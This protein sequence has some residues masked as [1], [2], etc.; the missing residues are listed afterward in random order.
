MAAAIT[1][2]IYRII[3]DSHPEVLPYYGSTIRSL[4]DRWW[5]HKNDNRCVSKQLMEFD[6]IRME[7]LE[8]FV[9]E[10]IIALRQR[11]QWYI[12]NHP[13]CNKSNAIGLDIENVKNI[14]KKYREA[15]I[16]ELNRKHR[17]YKE[18]HKEEINRKGREYMKQ[19]CEANKEEINRKKRERR[20]KKKLESSAVAST[21]KTEHATDR[22]TNAPS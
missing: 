20:A 5:K 4:K 7:L 8:E 18:V 13:C 6:D 15:H 14:K 12:D 11:E 16:E 3:S 22:I 1:G 10:S 2:R 9:C 17:E 19:Y 21:L